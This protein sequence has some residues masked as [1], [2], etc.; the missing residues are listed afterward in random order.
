MQSK[1]YFELNMKEIY[2]SIEKNL[3][4]KEKIIFY[5]KMKLNLMIRVFL[6]KIIKKQRKN[7]KMKQVVMKVK[8][9]NYFELIKTLI[10]KKYWD[11]AQFP[12]FHYSYK[13]I[14]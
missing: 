10:K 5:Q 9:R 4:K 6:K 2:F 3:Q 12:I 7:L 11:W 13:Y 14:L 8:M 1:Y